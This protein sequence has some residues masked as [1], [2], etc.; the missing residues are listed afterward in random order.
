MLKNLEKKI[1]QLLSFLRL[2]SI[3]N[4]F[5]FFLESVNEVINSENK[6]IS[7]TMVLKLD[8]YSG[9]TVLRI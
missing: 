1:T 3:Y 5:D 4:K 2:L 6:C 9:H 8:G 7:N